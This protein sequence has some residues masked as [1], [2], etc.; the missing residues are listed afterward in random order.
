V[1]G[2][3]GYDNVDMFGLGGIDLLRCML[4]LV[5][6]SI[7]LATANTYKIHCCETCCKDMLQHNNIAYMNHLYQIYT[8]W[9]G[10]LKPCCNC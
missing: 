2:N 1:H 9:G 3:N 6:T 7:G 5:I 8:G 4:L 10:F